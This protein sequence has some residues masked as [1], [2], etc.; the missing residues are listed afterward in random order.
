MVAAA[1]SPMLILQRSTHH[2]DEAVLLPFTIIQIAHALL[3]LVLS[4]HCTETESWFL[5][6]L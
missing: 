2:V 1:E 5:L 6:T 3:V 4:V